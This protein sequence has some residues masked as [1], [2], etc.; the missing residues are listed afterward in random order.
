[1]PNSPLAHLEGLLG[2]PYVPQGSRPPRRDV[3]KYFSDLA[4]QFPGVYTLWVFHPLLPFARPTVTV[5]DPELVTRLLEQ[6][7][8][9]AFCPSPVAVLCATSV[10]EGPL[11]AGL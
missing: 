6:D 7:K 11:H 3:F 10:A 5:T 4:V 9:R 8:V 2:T 1:M